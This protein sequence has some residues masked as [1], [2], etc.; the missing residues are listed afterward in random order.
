MA[1]L[2]QALEAEQREKFGSGKE[3]R[4]R[5]GDLVRVHLLIVEGRRE[6]VQV[7]EGTI[8]AMRGSG[9][10]RTVTVRRSCIISVNSK[11]RRRDCVSGLFSPPKSNSPTARRALHEG[12]MPV[13]LPFLCLK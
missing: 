4:L 11:G 6:R 8:I 3:E 2:V 9:L 7:F 5:P 13:T 1:D 12:S 10:N